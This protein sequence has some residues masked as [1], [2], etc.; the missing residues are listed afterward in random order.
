MGK[1]VRIGNLNST[2]NAENLK[3]IFSSCGTVIS[4][5]IAASQYSGKSRGFGFVEMTLPEEAL[6][7]IS[8]FD[9]K[10]HDGQVLSVTEAPFEKASRKTK[11]SAI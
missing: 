8:E 6:R 4:A 9:G 2:T 1:I 7:C 10:N 11:R 5:R 3:E